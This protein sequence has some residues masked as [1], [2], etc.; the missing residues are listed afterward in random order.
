MAG[1]DDINV[2]FD[3]D[4]KPNLSNW[5]DIW[6]LSDSFDIDSNTNAQYL[7]KNGYI[8]DENLWNTRLSSRVF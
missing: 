2:N 8:Q 4:K 7:I 3:G 1:I 6:A 5:I